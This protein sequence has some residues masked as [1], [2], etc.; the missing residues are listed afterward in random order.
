MNEIIL[1]LLQ[2]QGIDSIRGIIIKHNWF[3]N[4]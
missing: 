1:V 4:K 2:D 3:Q